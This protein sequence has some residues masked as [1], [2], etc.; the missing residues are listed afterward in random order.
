MLNGEPMA[1]ATS[2]VTLAGSIALANAEVLAG[3]ALVQLLE[4]GRPVVHNLGFAH[5]MEMRTGL[6][7]AGAVEGALMA[8]A[9]GRLAAHYRLPSASWMGTDAFLDDPQASLEKMLTGFAHLL[10]EVSILWGM[11]QLQSQKALS[12]TQLVM[13]EEIARALRRWWQGFRVDDETLAFPV[14]RDVVER[15]GD[16]LGHEHTLAHFREELWRSPLL[17][18]TYRETWEAEG[19][20]TLAERA[21]RHVEEVLATPGPPRLREEQERELLAIEERALLRCRED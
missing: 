5:V 17:A 18:R 8:C 9:G 2:P 16:F 13:D 3:I 1:G 15:G 11:G 14:L 7:L 6:C 20:T 19:A 21:R 4:P 12:L 10:G